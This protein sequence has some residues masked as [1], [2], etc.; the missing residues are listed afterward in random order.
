MSPLLNA[1]QSLT[2]LRFGS[3]QVPGFKSENFRTFLNSFREV[4]SF[5]ACPQIPVLKASFC[6]HFIAL[7]V[8]YSTIFST[9]SSIIYLWYSLVIYFTTISYSAI[10]VCP[11][12]SH[13]LPCGDSPIRSLWRCFTGEITIQHPV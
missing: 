9:I 3:S 1:R 8:G 11:P 7:K 12:I 4:Y 5:F 10:L 6:H 2:G 13:L